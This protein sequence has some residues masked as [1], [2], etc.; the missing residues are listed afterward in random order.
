M[1]LRRPAAAADQTL[2]RPLQVF[3]CYASGFGEALAH[4]RVQRLPLK[5][6][7]IDRDTL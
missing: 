5:G 6:Q 2:Q 7:A 4:S 3:L 1:H